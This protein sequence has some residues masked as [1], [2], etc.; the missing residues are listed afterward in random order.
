MSIDSRFDSRAFLFRLLLSAL[1]GVVLYALYYALNE[2]AWPAARPGLFAALL[3]LALILPGTYY[4][5][6][7]LARSRGYAIVLACAALLLTVV[8]WHH[9]ATAAPAAR[10]NYPGNEDQHAAFALVLLIIWLHGLPFM[11][12]W[13][14]TGRARPDY[15]TLFQFAWRNLLLVALGVVF[16]GAFWLLLGLW[17]QLF[18]S[19]GIKLFADIFTSAKFVI[20]ATAV[21]VGIGVQLAG[22]VENLQSALRRQLLTLFKW[23]APLAALIVGLFSMALIVKSGALFARGDSAIDAV[24]LLWLV[25]VNVYLLN[26]AYQD[27]SGDAPYP[28]VLGLMVRATVPLLSAIAVLALYALIVR[29]NQYGLTVPRV[30]GLFIAVIALV[31]AGGYAWAAISRGAW[32][33][34]MGT[35]NI[36]VALGVVATL[37]LMLTPAL[38]PARLAAASQEARIQKGSP[39]SEDAYRQLAFGTA[40]Y[41]RKRLQ[42]LAASHADAAV[43]TQAASALSAKNRWN[44]NDLAERTVPAR[45]LVIRA[46]PAGKTISPELLAATREQDRGVTFA[47]CSQADPCA[48]LFIDLNDDGHDEAVAY[49]DR[50]RR[51]YSEKQGR[52]VS[53]G[54]LTSREPQA[55]SAVIA[56]L[57]AGDYALR[58]PLWQPLEVGGKPTVVEPPW[59]DRF[60]VRPK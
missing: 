47:K 49:G 43:R 38:S 22:S 26:A 56:A 42:R 30:W 59:K 2:L 28:R 6:A 45:E 7:D 58:E 40:S 27:G 29:V 55:L 32:M 21:A 54:E 53:V 1:H 60:A 19:I 37:A 48:V 52:W 41:G 25:V 35:V 17:A 31:Y 20:P 46:Y 8:G 10:G 36:V 39:G 3:S 4:I 33:A 9:G 44:L 13:L 5:T 14:A 50:A 16:T 18:K 57:E 51:V 34:R 24:W 15:S 23:L 11:Q 12:S